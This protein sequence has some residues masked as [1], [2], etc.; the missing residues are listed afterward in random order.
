MSTVQILVENHPDLMRRNEVR[1]VAWMEVPRV[2]DM[3]PPAEVR[4]ALVD[5]LQL[6]EATAQAVAELDEEHAPSW[7]YTTKPIEGREPV[8]CVRC[9]PEDG[10]W[11]CI[12]RRIADELRKRLTPTEPEPVDDIGSLTPWLTPPPGH[13]TAWGDDGT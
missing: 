7:G 5:A 2:L 13:G 12:T 6:A 10:S 4:A 8:G 11:P 9:W 3:P 1:I